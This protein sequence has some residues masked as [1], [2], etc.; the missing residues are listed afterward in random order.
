MIK[1]K[2]P[3]M[4]AKSIDEMTVPLVK[5]EHFLEDEAEI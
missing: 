2:G 4:D 1:W 3:P 5:G